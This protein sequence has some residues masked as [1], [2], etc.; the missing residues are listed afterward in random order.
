MTTIQATTQPIQT[1]DG[2]S[3]SSGGNDIAAPN[4]PHH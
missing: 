4:Q 2:G 1:S 3:R